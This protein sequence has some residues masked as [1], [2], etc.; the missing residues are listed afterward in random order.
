VAVLHADGDA[1]NH[2]GTQ[3][4]S[5]ARWNG[6]DQAT[7][8]K[9]TRT[10]LDRFEQSRKSATGADGVHK[11]ALREYHGFAGGKVRGHHRK[12]DAEIFKPARIE[13]AFDQVLKALIA[14]QAESRDAPTG[15]VA[16]SQRAASINDAGQR[17]AASVGGAQDAA[18]AGS[19]DVRDGD[20]ILLED[21]QDAKMGEP[22]RETSAKG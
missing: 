6:G 15:D 5:R 14:C 3:V 22:A 20:V 4:A 2:G 1:D 9:T 7:I 17:R 8:S 18:H 13:N 10:D 19:C 16:E 21:L 12:R 11:V